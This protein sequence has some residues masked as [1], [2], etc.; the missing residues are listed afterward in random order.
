MLFEAPASAQFSR[1]RLLAIP[2]LGAAVAALYPH[3][4]DLPDP[5]Q[6]GNGPEVRLTLFAKNGR[7]QAVVEVRRLIRTD[8]E[9]RRRL[10]AA[11]FA[12]TRRQG[13]EFAFANRYWNCHDPGLYRCVCCGNALF[14]SEDKFSSGTGW[15]S[16][17]VPS[18]TTNIE[19]TIDTSYS[20]KRTEVRCR[21]CGAHLGHVFD[22]GP[23]PS[24][25]RYCLNSV[26]LRLVPYS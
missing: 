14:R 20:V 9:W 4:P 5:A 7:P 1:R 2:V 25:L 10:S 12:I 23:P 26:A 18:A 8:S 21:K 24:G 15:P 11:E 13:T 6:P 3:D 22:D 19:T 17:T 16:F